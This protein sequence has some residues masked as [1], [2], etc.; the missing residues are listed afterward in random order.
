MG[1]EAMYRLRTMLCKEVDEIAD[2]GELTAGALDTVHKLT[3]TIKNIDKI[4]MLEGGTSQRGYS[5]GGEWNAQG[6]YGNSYGNNGNSYG[7]THG[8]DYSGRMHYVRG[9]YSRD[10]Q[11][12]DMMM[13]HLQQMMQDADPQEQRMIEQ[14]MN[15]V[16]KR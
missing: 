13:E 7:D 16:K 14:W 8:R 4:E 1:K 2:K 12:E 10:A 15:E 3:D 5:R 11:G 9:H 6:S